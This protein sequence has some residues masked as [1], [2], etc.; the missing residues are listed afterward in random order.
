MTK[1]LRQEWIAIRSDIQFFFLR[2]PDIQFYNIQIIYL[3]IDT[4]DTT[5]TYL[6]QSGLGLEQ[7]GRFEPTKGPDLH[8]LREK[9]RKA[10]RQCEGDSTPNP[11]PALARPGSAHV[12]PL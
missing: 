10:R 3:T 9:D 1:V 6:G 12:F 11:T 2:K 7:P 8:P 5:L 4:E